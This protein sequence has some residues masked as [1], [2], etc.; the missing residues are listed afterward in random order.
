MNADEIARIESLWVKRGA[1]Q[2]EVRMVMRDRLTETP[3][4]GF[5]KEWLVSML[6]EDARAILVMAGP[7]GVGKTVAAVYAMMKCSPAAPVGFSAW[8]ESQAPRFRHASDV[9]ELG[10]FGSDD[11]KKA[12]AE[13]K[14][15]KTLVVDDL[16][17][18]YMTEQCKVLWDSLVNARYGSAGATILTTNL[19][20]DQFANRYGERVFDRIRGRGEWYDIDGESM[21]GRPTT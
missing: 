12:R 11:D 19:T 1:P 5:A 21:R 6:K 15:C 3:A 20:H 7:K 18:E 9:A 2:A 8:P 13:L 16:G 17:A 14:R 10:V 4:L